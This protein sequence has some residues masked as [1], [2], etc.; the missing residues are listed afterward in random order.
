[1]KPLIP[2]IRIAVFA[3]CATLTWLIAPFHWVGFVALAVLWSLRAVTVLTR[4]DRYSATDFVA[5]IVALAAIVTFRDESLLAA[6]ALAA[7]SLF[8]VRGRVMGTRTPANVQGPVAATFRHASASPPQRRPAPRSHS[9]PRPT[10]RPMKTEPLRP[11]SDPLPT[12]NLHTHRRAPALP[13]TPQ[14]PATEPTREPPIVP[15]TPRTESPEHTAKS[16]FRRLD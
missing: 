16:R 9:T 1:M 14:P 3:A 8:L 2:L 15:P 6:T 5:G 12:G 11:F 4:G 10:F 7:A 13:S